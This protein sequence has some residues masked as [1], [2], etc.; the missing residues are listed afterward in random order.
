M[1]RRHSNGGRYFRCFHAID[2]AIIIVTHG[3]VDIIIV[4]HGLVD[5][6]TFLSPAVV[7]ELRMTFL[8]VR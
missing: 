1:S 8:F 5:L 6:T 2:A 3:L 4:T 7:F